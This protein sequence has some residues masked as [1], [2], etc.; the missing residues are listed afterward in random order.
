MIL[1]LMLALLPDY[2]L[3]LIFIGTFVFALNH[4]MNLKNIDKNLPE[5]KSII[6]YL[7]RSYNAYYQYR[8]EIKEYYHLPQVRNIY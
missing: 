6:D 1:A 7:R 2:D 5:E 3:P 4:F 8:K